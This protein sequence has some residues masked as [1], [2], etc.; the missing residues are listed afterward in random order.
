MRRATFTAAN[1]TSPSS[2]K[3]CDVRLRLGRGLASGLVDRLLELA[4]LVVEV[5]ERTAY[6]RILEVDR[7]RAP[8]HLA[9]EEQRRQRL[10]H[11][12]ED[13]LASLL[14]AL[15]LSQFERTRTALS[16]STSPKTCGCRR[17]SFS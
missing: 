7:R 10:R 9:R 2:S 14:L 11:V 16:A 1:S 12:V 13:A 4:K 17:T 5:V 8:L 6:V 15:D 3:T